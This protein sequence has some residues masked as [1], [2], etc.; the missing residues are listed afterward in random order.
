MRCKHTINVTETRRFALLRMMQPTGPIDRDITLAAIQPR[1]ALHTA[2]C[3]DA[4]KLKQAIEDGTVISHVVLALL[5]TKLLHIIRGHALQEIDVLVSMELGHLV[6]GSGL[7]AV[8]LEVL[9]EV[10]VHNEGVGHP[11]TMGFHG[12]PGIV[13]VVA[14]VGV[15]EVGDLLGLRGGLGRVDGGVIAHDAVAVG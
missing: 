5:A 13:G 9:V 11:D 3:A 12:V 14:D 10:V 7:R 6:L 8:D 15:V 2:T 4:A 1:G